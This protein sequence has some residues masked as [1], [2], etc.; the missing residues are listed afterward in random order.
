MPCAAPPVGGGEGLV[1]WCV[2]LV[3]WLL[4]WWC[5]CGLVFGIGDVV[6]D[7]AVLVGYARAQ[8]CPPDIP[9]DIALLRASATV[10]ARARCAR[11]SMEEGMIMR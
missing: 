10:V 7:V 8:R 4:F 5:A 9:P 3:M 11:G 2:G 6:T 1:V